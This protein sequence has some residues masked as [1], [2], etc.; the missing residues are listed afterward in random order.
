MRCI[1]L[2]N[3]YLPPAEVLLTEITRESRGN[4][5]IIHHHSAFALRENPKFVLIDERK[6]RRIAEQIY[7]L[8]LIGTAGILLRAKLQGFLF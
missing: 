6:G 7:R 1:P 5:Y 3:F 2:W 8:P 4:F